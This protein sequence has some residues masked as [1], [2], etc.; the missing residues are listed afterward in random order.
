MK[1][2]SASVGMSLIRRA[3]AHTPERLQLDKSNSRTGDRRPYGRGGFVPGRV[4]SSRDERTGNGQRDP[5]G[6][7]GGQFIS[8]T[9]PVRPTCLEHS[10]PVC[11]GR[12]CSIFLFDR[13][14]H[15]L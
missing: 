15:T 1:N 14:I 12:K 13:M 11:A 8:R 3:A 4:G 10:Q 9:V 7:L 5:S 6:C 2:G